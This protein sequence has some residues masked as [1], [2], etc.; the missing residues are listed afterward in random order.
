V[1]AGVARADQILLT[2]RSYGGYL[3]LMGLGKRPYLWA[4]GMAAAAMADMAVN[5]EDSADTFRGFAV[6][7]FGCTPQ[8]CP[9][10]YANSSPLTYAEHVAAP[11]LIVQGRHDTRT[12]A[13]SIEMYEA[14]LRALGKPIEV[15][16]FEAGHLGAGVERDIE[17]QEL[18]LRF[19]YRVLGK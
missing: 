13:R 12:L 15:H 1:Q 19:A 17:H 10:R 5:F 8:E 16:W 14:K 7:L 9:E 2:G 18:M 6:A 11:V 4:G 3:T